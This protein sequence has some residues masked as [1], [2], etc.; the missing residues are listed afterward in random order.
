MNPLEASRTAL[1]TAL[2]RAR[3][4]R[5]DVNPLIDDPWGDVLVPAVVREIIGAR[6][7]AD[8]PAPADMD[9]LI[10]DW[11]G[12]HTAYPNVIIRTRYTEDCLRT[13]IESGTSQYVLLGAGFDSFSLRRPPYAEAIDIYEVDHPATQTLKRERIA[14]SGAV[15]SSKVHMVA[16]DFAQ[17]DLATALARSPYQPKARTFFSWLGVT[18]YLTYKANMATFRAVALCSPPGS[19]ITFTYVDNRIY[20]PQYQTVAFRELQ[21]EVAAIG[22]PF[23]S[24][25]DPATLD[26]ELRAVGLT[27]VEDLNGDTILARYGAVGTQKPGPA[28]FSHIARARVL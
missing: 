5:L 11:L 6:L 18:N 2:M 7:T 15:L 1:T 22:E 13:A 16:I 3:H 14:E 24:G 23:Q 4:T 17:E 28:T 21:A 20:E 19:E 27:L 26:D 10:D 8:R 25:F 12:A 9:N